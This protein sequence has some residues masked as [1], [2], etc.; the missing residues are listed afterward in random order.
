MDSQWITFD[1][2]ASIEFAEEKKTTKKCDGD[3]YIYIYI[4]LS[5]SLDLLAFEQIDRKLAGG[6]KMM[7]VCAMIC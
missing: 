1:T 2:R 5:L 3:L 6:S 4:Y 7:N